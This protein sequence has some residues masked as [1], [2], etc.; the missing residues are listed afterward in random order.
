MRCTPNF[1]TR[2]FDVYHN[3]NNMVFSVADYG[4]TAFTYV[5]KSEKGYIFHSYQHKEHCFLKLQILRESVLFQKQVSRLGCSIL[6][7]VHSLVVTR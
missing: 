7:S 2:F 4:H 3:S 5:N 6:T 1:S